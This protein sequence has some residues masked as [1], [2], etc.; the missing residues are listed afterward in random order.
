MEI[1][2]DRK[3]LPQMNTMNAVYK[4]TEQAL[5]ENTD[6]SD[7][8]EVLA[9]LQQSVVD[10]DEYL[11]Y[12]ISE[13]FNMLM[14]SLFEAHKKDKLSPEQSEAMAEVKEAVDTFLETRKTETA[15][16]AKAILMCKQLGLN[17]AR[18]TDEEWRVL[19]KTL[20]N[21]APVRR[22]KKRK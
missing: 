3:V 11:R 16:K 8:D 20:E 6:I 2:I 21:S 15:N 13:R 1:Y 14:V 18:L 9:F 12:R 4:V 10:E 5:R 19:M 17:T 22:V 7:N